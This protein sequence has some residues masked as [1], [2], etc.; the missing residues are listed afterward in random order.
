MQKIFLIRHAE[1]QGQSPEAQ[2]T[3]N[4]LKQARELADFFNG[5]DVERII[6]SPYLRAIQTIEP[7]A[8]QL[9]IEVE[10]DDQLKERLL[11]STPLPDWY[12]SLRATFEDFDLAY[13]G[14]ESSRAAT[15]RAIGVLDRVITEGKNTILV[16]HGN[17]MALLLHHLDQAFGFEEWSRLQNPD[18]YLLTVKGDAKTLERIWS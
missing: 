9:A 5:I 17:L 6:S 7:L 10:Q 11:S 16:T 8:D 12:E 3:E 13:E 14:G 4:G 18:V 1:A 2:L 15:I